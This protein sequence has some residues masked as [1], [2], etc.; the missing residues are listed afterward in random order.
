MTAMPYVDGSDRLSNLLGPVSEIVSAY[1]SNNHVAAIELPA[2]LAS[3]HAELLRVASCALGPTAVVIKKPS[4]REIRDSLSRD[5]ITSFL[6]GRVYK[7]LRRHLSCHGLTPMTYRQRYGL[8]HDYPMTAPAYS[9]RRTAISKA[10]GVS[11]A[12]TAET[13]SSAD[14]PVTKYREK[15]A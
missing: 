6:D 10:I 11:R 9:E 1:V 15:V 7:M 2:L 5:G 4:A 14:V 3:V 8:P 12:R 13:A